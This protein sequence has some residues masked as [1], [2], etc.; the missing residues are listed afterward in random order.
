MLYDFLEGN[1][2]TFL[3]EK[4]KA[5]FVRESKFEIDP[6]EGITFDLVK[7]KDG[8]FLFQ[9]GEQEYYVFAYKKKFATVSYGTLPKFHITD[10]E[11]RETYSGYR[12]ANQMPV[13]IYCIDQRINLGAQHLELCKNCIRK[14]NFFSFGTSDL[15]WYD[16]ILKNAGNRNYTNEDLRLDGYTRDWNHV[17]KAYRFKNDFT[18]ETCGVNLSSRKAEFFCEVHHK[19][20]NKTN[21]S[22]ENLECL[23]VKCHAEQ[24]IQ[25]YSSGKNKAKLEQFELQ[26]S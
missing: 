19:D 9:K 7:K 23:C 3:M 12:F 2:A 13:E 24:H 11:T 15:K 25:N 22:P 16:V 4:L 26:F 5:R 14:I 18:C 6:I 10:C 21:N 17:S 8:S 1:T 20:K